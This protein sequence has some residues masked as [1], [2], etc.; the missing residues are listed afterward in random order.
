MKP[1]TVFAAALAMAEAAPRRAFLVDR[2]GELSYGETCARLHKVAG[3]LAGWGLRPGARVLLASREDRS[4]AVLFLALLGCGMTAVLLDPDTGP[5]RARRLIEVSAP[6]ACLVEQDLIAAWGLGGPLLALAPE[7][8][9]GFLERLRPGRAAPETYPGRLA[10]LAPGPLPERL[11]P[12]LD[13]YVMFT[14][15][16]T[17]EPKGVRITRRALFDHMDTLARVYGLGPGSAIFNNLIL[18]HA[19]GINQGPVLAFLNRLP[20]VRPFPFRIQ[21]LEE[22]L[23]ALYRHRVSHLIAVPTMLAL[24]ERYC[25]DR[26]EAFRGADFRLVVSCGAPL[27]ADLWRRFEE[28][29]GVP[30]VNLYGLTETVN[31]GLFAGPGDATRRHGTVGRP[32]DCEARIVAADGRVCADLEPGEVQ[33]RGTLVMAGYLHAPEATARVLGADGWFRTGDLGLREADGCYRI[34]GRAKELIIRGGFNVHPGEVTEVLLGHPAVLEAVTF[35]QPDAIWGEQ[36]RS[37]VVAAPGSGLDE[38]A[39]LEYA[40]TRL[41][42]QK[43]PAR[44]AFLPG[45]PRGRSGKV[46]LEEVGSLA[47]AALLE[48][49]QGLLEG[50]PPAGGLVDGILAEAARCFR[51]SPAAL[52]LA[53]SPLVCPGWDSMAHLE[54]VAALEAR[55]A[56]QL[57]PDDILALGCLGDAVRIV[58]AAVPAP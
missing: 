51:V 27:E 22:M 53:S 9:A 32:V 34:L 29:F 6:E 50:A 28:T 58:A 45:L 47:R 40:G 37:A 24:L 44:I 19:D 48:A 10:G 12:D 4:T 38:A 35:G 56:I 5:E 15:G 13:A 14:S 43:V 30:V 42:G 31:G 7:T 39:L 33:M 49:P 52:D 1:E 25:P 23:D 54:F 57:R 41:E 18:S 46:A 36:V 55:F 17:S 11:D 8:R 21:N 3:L 20:L 26:R 2:L 16:T